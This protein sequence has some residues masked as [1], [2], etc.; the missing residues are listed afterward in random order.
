[1]SMKFMDGFDHYAA[2]SESAANIA[3]LLTA[4]GY[5]VGNAA[6]NKLNVVAGQDANSSGIK[7][8]ID[9]GSSTP[10]NISFAHTTTA[11]N[12]FFGFSFNGKG[13]RVRVARINGVVDLAW[14]TTTGK[15][16]IG[17]VEGQ[18]VIIMNAYWFIEIELDKVAN[19][20]RVWANDTLQLEAD[21]PGGAVTNNH[22]IQW[23]LT[24]ANASAATIELDD[25][26]IADNS[27]GIQNTRCGPLQVITRAPT[28]DVTTEW[29]PQ[30]SAGT[31]ASIAAQ[32]SPNA[33]NAPYLQANV[34][35]KTDRFSSNTV[36]PNDNQ[37][38]GVQLVAYARKGDL[39]NRSLGMLVKTTAGEVETQVALAT[40][41]AYKTSMYEQ[42]PGA[43]P[44][45][46]NRV[47][48]S[49][50]GIVAR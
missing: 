44:W 10:P 42:A 9:A 7:L 22:V 38:F 18:D 39:D 11:D 46:Q 25:F 13:S 50:F 49:N 48:S 32:L 35:G 3:S 30:G 24:G 29:T 28:T 43:V 36:L 2:S 5:T 26:Y 6:N 4:A 23:G 27:G 1:M 21:L 20:V 41:Y 47:E 33:A 31:H 15:L 17:A 37:I 45:N 14:S 19:K 12:V 8:T 40:T 34:E 16:G